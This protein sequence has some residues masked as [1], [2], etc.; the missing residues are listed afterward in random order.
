VPYAEVFDR[1]RVLAQLDLTKRAI[2]EHLRKGR[3][4]LRRGDEIATEAEL[5]DA[6]SEIDASL[7]RERAV[8]AAPAIQPGGVYLP[9]DPLISCLQAGIVRGIEAASDTTGAAQMLALGERDRGDLVDAIAHGSRP[10]PAVTGRHVPEQD[11]RPPDAAELVFEPGSFKPFPGDLGW[12][13]IGVALA[14]RALHGK[15]PYNSTPAVATLSP[16]ARMY[17][18][19]DWGTGIERAVQLSGEVRHRLRRDASRYDHHVIHLGDVYYAG[20]PHEYTEHVLLAWPVPAS[21]PE[22]GVSW[23]LCG[24]HDMYYGGEGYYKTCLED[25]RFRAQRCSSGKPTSTF[26]LSNEHWRILGLDTGWVDVGLWDEEKEWLKRS[27]LEA[28]ASG[29]SVLL[30]SHHQLFS[31]FAGHID[32]ELSEELGAFLR[33][34]PV[35]A[36][37][38]GHEHRCTLYKPT[39]EVKHARCIGNSGVPAHPTP[40]SAVSDPDIIELDYEELRQPVED[41]GPWVRFAFAALEFKGSELNV[42]Y[43]DEDGGEF[44][45][46]VL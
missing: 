34:H 15:Y 13:L 9:R 11:E 26:E 8:E 46:E 18:F 1:D 2:E 14:R 10:L 39:A 44:A 38:W 40:K 22:L 24:N 20:W 12:S 4:E 31:G 37:F 42:V 36:W 45:P 41:D 19:S 25:E 43:V 7:D 29:Q 33:E 6:L 17:L 21:D 30:L 28:E 3:G 5:R 35:R 32:Q 27:I 23:I 16:T